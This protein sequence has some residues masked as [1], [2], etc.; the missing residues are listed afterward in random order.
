[1]NNNVIV[2]RLSTIG[3]KAEVFTEIC[4][5]GDKKIILSSKKTDEVLEKINENQSGYL[6]VS[7]KYD[8]K[9]DSSKSKKA[10]WL[11]WKQ[12]SDNKLVNFELYEMKEDNRGKFLFELAL[13]KKQVED[14]N[15]IHQYYTNVLEQIKLAEEKAKL[16]EPDFLSRNE[17]E[18]ENPYLN[19]Q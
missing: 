5:A 2:D 6:E 13:T 16:L 10:K 9:I 14:F 8:D 1:M 18:D 7:K 19:K 4:G 12:D 15:P 17:D 11:K 3:D